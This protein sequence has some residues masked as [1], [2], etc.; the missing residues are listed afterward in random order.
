MSL[1]AVQSVNDDISGGQTG[2]D[3]AGFDFATTR[4]IPHGGCCPGA[5]GQRVA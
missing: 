4:D 2:A 3:R 5:D 1:Y